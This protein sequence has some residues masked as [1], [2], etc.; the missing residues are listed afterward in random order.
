MPTPTFLGRKYAKPLVGLTALGILTHGVLPGWLGQWGATPTEREMP[1]PGDSLTGEIAT[2]QTMVVPIAARP[3]QVWPWLVQMGIDRAGFYSWLWVENGLMRL[4]AINADRIHPEWQDLRVG[5]MMAFTPARSFRGRTGPR[6]VEIDPGRSIVL[7]ISPGAPEGTVY[8][9]W[10]FLLA[11]AG[12]GTTRLV[13]RTR[14]DRHRPLALRIM[15]GV[16]QPGYLLMD[17]AMLLGIR[18]RAERLAR[19][20]QPSGKLDPADMETPAHPAPTAESRAEPAASV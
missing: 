9:T 1:V 11:D 10:Q 19:Q 14:T 18:H 6:V 2:Q 16:F 3:D 5:D 8:A 4:G 15:D 7:D 20:E 13:L 17:R 12:G